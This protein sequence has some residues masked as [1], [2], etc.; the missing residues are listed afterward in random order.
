MTISDDCLSK[1]LFDSNND[2][3]PFHQ[4]KVFTNIEA[5]PGY[6]RLSNV[7]ISTFY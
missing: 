7:G 1:M 4:E 5:L 6:M 2:N 3:A